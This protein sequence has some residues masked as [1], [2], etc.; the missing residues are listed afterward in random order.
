MHLP[1]SL[2]RLRLNTIELDSFEASR[3]SILTKQIEHA[4]FL[5]EFSI[6]RQNYS[7]PSLDD[8]NDLVILIENAFK[9]VFSIEGEESALLEILLIYNIMLL[10]SNKFDDVFKNLE[11]WREILFSITKWPLELISMMQLFAGILFEEQNMS[12]SEREYLMSL[13]H[14]FVVMGDPRVKNIYSLFWI[15]IRNLFNIVFERFLYK[16]SI[17]L[18]LLYKLLFFY[19]ESWIYL[20]F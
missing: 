7:L 17:E 1:S 6:L 14:Y 16:W 8:F 19:W 11:K 15:I 10:I 12:E 4:D 3:L 20:Y 9:D 2:Y 5:Q 18:S 13:I